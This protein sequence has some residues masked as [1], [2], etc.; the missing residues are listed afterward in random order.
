[1]LRLFVYRNAIVSRF[2]HAMMESVDHPNELVSQTSID[3]LS[4]FSAIYDKIVH[5]D[6]VRG[7]DTNNNDSIIH[8]LVLFLSF[9]ISYFLLLLLLTIHIYSLLL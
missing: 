8:R 1:M 6:K 2:V 9:L 7:I 5:L 3:C 4:S